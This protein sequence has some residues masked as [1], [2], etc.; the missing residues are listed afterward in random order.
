MSMRGTVMEKVDE[1]M[2]LCDLIG[3]NKN[4]KNVEKRISKGPGIITQIINLLE[5]VSFGGHYIEIS[6]L[7]R[8]FMFINGILFNVEVRYGITKAE[9]EEFEKP[10]RL[11]PRIIL[12]AP[13]S[14]SSS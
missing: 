2:Y 9:V 14:T 7:L 5:I 1:D 6:L 10:D 13:V 3:K 8:E 12:Q 11:L 4:K